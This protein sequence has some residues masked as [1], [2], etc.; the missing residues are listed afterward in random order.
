M[1]IIAERCYR[2]HWRDNGRTMELEIIQKERLKEK[3]KKKQLV[4]TTGTGL[5]VYTGMG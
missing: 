5:L 1:D 4:S 2:H 3:I